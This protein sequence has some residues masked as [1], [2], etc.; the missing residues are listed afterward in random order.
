MGA[1]SSFEVQSSLQARV[2]LCDES[3]PGHTC[4][5]V[6]AASVRGGKTLCGVTRVWGQLERVL[7]VLEHLLP[8]Y[9]FMEMQ[10][11]PCRCRKVMARQITCMLV[12]GG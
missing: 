1:G 8:L 2:Q 11:S 10:H 5:S 6:A 4:S 9:G 3:T 12:W 7:L